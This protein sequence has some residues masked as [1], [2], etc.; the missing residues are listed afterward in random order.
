[1][2]VIVLLAIR[3]LGFL[4]LGGIF[5][6]ENREERVVF[7]SS[8]CLLSK[9]SAD[10]F[11]W[12][13]K[14]SEWQYPGDEVGHYISIYSKGK[15]RVPYGWVEVKNWVRAAKISRCT[16]ISCVLMDIRILNIRTRTRLPD[17]L[18]QT[19]GKIRQITAVFS[20]KWESSKQRDLR[21]AERDLRQ[22]ERLREGKQII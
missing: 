3:H 16:R 11:I 19:S 22:A 9:E 21:E 14:S 20:Y 2:H 7:R 15:K 4:E 1:M 6:I 18:H 12:I 10:A 5:P 13:L 17:N 8:K